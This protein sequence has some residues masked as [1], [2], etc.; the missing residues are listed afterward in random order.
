MAWHRLGSGF[1]FRL[2][3]FFQLTVIRVHGPSVRPYVLAPGTPKARVERLLTICRPLVSDSRHHKQK[4]SAHGTL[5]RYRRIQTLLRAATN[6]RAN[7][8]RARAHARPV[9]GL[10]AQR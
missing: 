6:L 1:C 8:A 7:N 10:V 9:R 3:A 4:G 2:T 5:A